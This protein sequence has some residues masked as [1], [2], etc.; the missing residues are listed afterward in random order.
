[1][2]VAV[3]VAGTP[4][5]V[6]VIRVISS[7]T[8]SSTS[9]LTTESLSSLPPNRANSKRP[10]KTTSTAAPAAIPPGPRYHGWSSF[11]TGPPGAGLNGA[12]AAVMGCTMVGSVGFPPRG[13]KSPGL[14]AGE[15]GTSLIP[16]FVAGLQRSAVDTRT[17][18]SQ[19]R[20]TR[21]NGN[22][23]LQWCPTSAADRGARRRC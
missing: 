21:V 11:G 6:R 20:T 7:W 22:R 1:M 5:S 2:T 13:G 12:P 3:S 9:V 17:F 16:L 4:S 23:G 19:S 14:P 8:E 18:L 15:P 10:S